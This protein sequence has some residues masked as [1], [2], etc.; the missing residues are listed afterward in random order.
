MTVRGGFTVDRLQTRSLMPRDS[1]RQL[2]SDLRYGKSLNYET[3]C[4]F[5]GL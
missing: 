1:P 3:V 5:L 2:A 4:D